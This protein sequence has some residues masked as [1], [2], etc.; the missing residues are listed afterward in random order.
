[1]LA[2]T[3]ILFGSQRFTHKSTSSTIARFVFMP[4]KL[5]C[6]ANDKAS[7]VYQ[8]ANVAKQI[9]NNAFE[10]DKGYNPDKIIIYPIL[11][12]GDRTFA[13]PGI[14]VILNDYFKKRLIKLGLSTA[15]IKDISLIDI[16]TLI[17]FE[18]DFSRNVIQLKD[19]LDGYYK[20]LK[21]E[22]PYRVKDAN[23]VIFNIVHTNFSLATYMKTKIP[24]R[25]RVGY[26]DALIKR[27]ERANLN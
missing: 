8:L 23:D 11:V 15:N 1:M 17:N 6:K 27:F 18:E 4:I 13:S 2:A 3:L 14:S 26:I 21:A 16:D 9:L 7:A 20:F 25:N 19:V 24:P 22:F 10:A 12:V 5:V